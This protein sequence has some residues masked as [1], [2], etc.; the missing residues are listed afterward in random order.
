MFSANVL[1]EDAVWA[2]FRMAL[3]EGKISVAK[4]AVQRLDRSVTGYLRLLDS[5]YENPQ[6]TLE[7]RVSSP[8]NRFSREIYL[9]AL[10]R[11]VRNQPALAQDFWANLQN[12]YAQEDQAYLWGR[13]ALAAAKRLDPAAMEMYKKSD[14]IY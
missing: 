7:R 14:R 6:K 3:Q 4:S 12:A 13:F 9:Y 11:V 8:A 1:T 10:D 2:R 5:A